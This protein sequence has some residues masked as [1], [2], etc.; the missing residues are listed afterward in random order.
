[1]LALEVI[2]ELLKQYGKKYRITLVWWSLKFMTTF[3][4]KN[5]ILLEKMMYDREKLREKVSE[6]VGCLN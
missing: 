5:D 6:W 4:Y 1:M 2:S 3:K